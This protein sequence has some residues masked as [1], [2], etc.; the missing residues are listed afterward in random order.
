MTKTNSNASRT[1]RPCFALLIA[2]L[3]AGAAAQ[4]VDA[5]AAAPLR[6]QEIRCAGNA[7]TS[8]EFLR[9]KLHLTAGDTLDEEEVRNAQLRLASLRNFTSAHVRLE[10][11]AERGAVIV[12]L[13]VEEADPIAM[14][15]I[16]GLA[17]RISWQYSQLGARVAHQNLFGTGKY[18]E[19]G[20][21][22]FVPLHDDPN[23][24][25]QSVFLRYADPQLFDSRRWFGQ[26][27]VGWAKHDAATEDGNFTHREGLQLSA[28]VGWRFADFSYL[29]IGTSWRPGVEAVR[30]LWY[31]DG[32]FRFDDDSERFENTVD[33]N[34][35]WNSEDD[36]HFPTR[37]STFQVGLSVHLRGNEGVTVGGV[38]FRKTWSAAG[39]YWSIALGGDPTNEYRFSFHESQLIG[40]MYARPIEPGPNIRRGRWYIE[41]GLDVGFRTPEGDTRYGAGL[42]VGW[43]A[44]TR[45]FGVVN[46][47]ILGSTD[48]A[49]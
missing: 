14:E 29:T 35:G 5:V 45:Q 10:K 33:L 13:Q 2:S 11:G 30:G 20:A 4:N 46:F 48:W 49:Q 22:A 19:L 32:T 17:D 9:E 24:E 21:V 25:M 15:F 3:S 34:Y 16:A 47:F 18:A 41:P 40:F 26:A 23:F 8:C 38:Q 44:E 36:L 7:N 28:S 27:S 31:G 43:R 1:V 6:V 37:G 12:V 42:K 39:G